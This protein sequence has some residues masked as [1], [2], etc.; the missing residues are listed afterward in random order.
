MKCGETEHPLLSKHL[1]KNNT[2]KCLSNSSIKKWFSGKT[3]GILD[4][5]NWIDFTDF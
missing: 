1:K 5:Q 2:A 4:K 3:I